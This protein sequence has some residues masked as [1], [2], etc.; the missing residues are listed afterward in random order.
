MCAFE[1]NPRFICS[2]FSHFLFPLQAE[3]QKAM[4]S[5]AAD[6]TLHIQRIKN[7][8]KAVGE[9]AS[10]VVASGNSS[11]DTK[12]TQG[13]KDLCANLKKR[14]LEDPAASEGT[15]RCTPTPEL[16]T[17]QQISCSSIACDASSQADI[18]DLA[19]PKAE[20]SSDGPPS[21]RK[22]AHRPR[23]EVE[24]FEEPAIPSHSVSGPTFVA[25]QLSAHHNAAHIRPYS[26]APALPAIPPQQAFRPSNE[27]IPAISEDS[28]SSSVVF[29]SKQALKAPDAERSVINPQ[30][31]SGTHS[32]SNLTEEEE[33]ISI[34]QWKSK[35]RNIVNDRS[36]DP[37]SVGP[38]NCPRCTFYN[39]VRIGSRSKCAMCEGPRATSLPT[40]NC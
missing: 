21:A 6:H 5:G 9:G 26:S 29:V 14:K 36:C 35:L 11:F 8:R 3:E 25:S 22:D 30:T 27:I 37:P 28:N 19:H 40:A 23:T 18:L 15:Q 16:G 34:Q 38:W 12:L 31:T 24:S 2:R 10:V 1:Y 17:P 20:D 33:S 4:L 39:T 7:A 13:F 32:K